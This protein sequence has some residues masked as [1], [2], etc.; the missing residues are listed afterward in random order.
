MS[1]ITLNTEKG[2]AL[3][4]ANSLSKEEF[5]ELYQKADDDIKELIECLLTD[6]RLLP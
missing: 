6:S 3:D 5:I 2:I 1:N 4:N